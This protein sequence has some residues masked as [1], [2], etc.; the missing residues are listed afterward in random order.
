MCKD[1]VLLTDGAFFYVLFD[2]GSCLW[3]E[4]VAVNLSSHLVPP[5]MPPSFVVVPLFQD[6]VFELFVWWY[7]ES[8][9]WVVFPHYASYS[10]SKNLS[11]VLN[12]LIVV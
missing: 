6:F 3:L 10:A 1:L 7:G 12:I 2:L 8:V 9:F 4:I 5:S 11:N